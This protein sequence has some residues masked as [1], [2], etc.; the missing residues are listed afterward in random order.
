MS[1][2]GSLAPANIE[3][4]KDLGTGDAATWKYWESQ[5][6][7]AT[8]E[9]GKWPDYGRGIVARYRDQREDGIGSKLHRFN[10]LWSNVQT[11]LPTYYA[12]TPKPEVVRR[13]NDADPTGRMASM[14]LERCLSYMLDP[15]G[16]SQFDS[17]MRAVVLDQLLPGRGVARVLYVPKFGDKLP[18][19]VPAEDQ[20]TNA[21]FADGQ[22]AAAEVDSPGDA[23]E[24][25]AR[26]VVDEDVVV[27]YTY[28]E[29]YQ[30]GPAR[31]WE[32]VPWL[33]Y[34]G[35]MTRDELIARFGRKK[36][37]KVNLDHP[38]TPDTQHKDDPPPDLYKKAVIHE[39]WDKAKKEVVWIA[40]GTP[41]LVLDQ[42]D[43]P[44]ELPDF[45]PSPDPLLSTT[46]TDSRIPVPDYIEY[47]DQAQELD[48][49]TTR[50]DLLT[51]ALKVS[52]V[53]PGEQKQVLQQLV[54]GDNENRLYPV[55]D[56]VAWIDKGGM[57][58]MIQWVPIEQIAGALIQLYDARDRT[59][60]ILYEI[61]GI[62]DI[63]RGET[64][65]NETATAQRLKSNF[66]TR[67]IV[68]KQKEV[69]RFARDM[70]RLMAGVI[71]GHFQAS[72]VSRITGYP[73][74][75]PVPELPPAPP[76][77]LPA[78]PM[79]MP[80]QMPGQGQGMPMPQQGMVG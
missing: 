70:I 63:L 30:E 65:P 16:G 32:E 29:D 72:T 14:L 52:G 28:W 80:G 25:D 48:K 35:Y 45:F 17:M 1:D 2:S 49:I 15:A 19:R 23:S 79:Q 43:D 36:G 57:K 64:V 22:D 53:Y 77:Y 31:T 74:L 10:I 71:S 11:L 39:Y 26:E 67:R 7:I 37:E 44:L 46:T 51:Q 41:D 27:R 47:R 5:E 8:K 21:D 54:G 55:E 3:Q 40:P 61:T 18:P 73:Q 9:M 50:I 75:V 66:A 20:T 33:R 76:Q 38:K 56:W 13:W 12:R 24:D 34:K 58:E 4:R 60:Q 42:Q 62:G 68:P 6:D 69:A 78:P 59:K